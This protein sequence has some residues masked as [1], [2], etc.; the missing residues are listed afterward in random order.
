M[1]Y[2]CGMDPNYDKYVFP[3]FSDI[4]FNTV[5]TNVASKVSHIFMK[6]YK[7]VYGIVWHYITIEWSY[8]VKIYEL[9][10][11]IFIC[12]ILSLLFLYDETI[13]AIILIY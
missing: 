12:L 9:Y 13:L 10:Y 11:F 6:V 3:E 2:T 8:G 5:E 4:L 1:A 7:H